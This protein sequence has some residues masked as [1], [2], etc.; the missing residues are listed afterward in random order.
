METQFGK[1]YAENKLKNFWYP[2]KTRLDRNA[3][4]LRPGQSTVSSYN[5]ISNTSAITLPF[6]PNPSSLPQIPTP[7]I[8][9]PQFQPNI[10]FETPD[11]M[12]PSF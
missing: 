5:P 7:S 11:R 10:Q 1:L 12:N 6:P 2:R 8:I 3:G 4:S 9:E